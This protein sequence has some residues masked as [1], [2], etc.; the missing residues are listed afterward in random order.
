[1]IYVDSSV[2]LAS[3]MTEARKP[4][5]TLW[6]AERLSSSRLLEYEVWNRAFARGIGETHRAEIAAMLRKIDFVELSRDRLQRALRPF[7]LQVRTLDGLHLATM[8]FLRQNGELIQLASYDNRLLA[9]AQALG[10]PLAAC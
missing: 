6:A 5:E 1:M 3:V 4:P 7:P 8:D 2:A 10:I 9:A